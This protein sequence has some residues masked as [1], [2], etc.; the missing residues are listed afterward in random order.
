MI[1][2]HFLKTYKTQKECHL[3]LYNLAFSVYKISCDLGSVVADR[4]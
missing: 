2:P 4:W 1:H 3:F